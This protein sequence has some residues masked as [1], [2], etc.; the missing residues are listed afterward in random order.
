M[1]RHRKWQLFLRETA[2]RHVQRRLH[3]DAVHFFR[4]DAFALRHSYHTTLVTPTQIS[5]NI[6]FHTTLFAF[7]TPNVTKFWTSDVLCLHNHGLLLY[8]AI[9][10]PFSLPAHHFIILTVSLHNNPTFY[11]AHTLILLSK[12]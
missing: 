8:T 4:S 11:F 12:T 9:S 7:A 3:V 2:Q 6:Y 5:Y 10:I 1:G